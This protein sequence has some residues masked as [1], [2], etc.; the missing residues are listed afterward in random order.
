MYILYKDTS[1]DFLLSPWVSTELCGAGRHRGVFFLFIY[2]QSCV[3]RE[4]FL[5]LFTFSLFIHRTV[6]REKTSCDFLFHYLSTKCVAWEDIVRFSTFSLFIHRTVWCGKTSCDF[7]LF[8]YP[9]TRRTVWRGKTSCDFPFFS[10]FM[11]RIVRSGKTSCD[12][13]L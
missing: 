7:L 6:W 3:A 4:D 11:H 5:W 2:P 12:F 8:I 1:C 9:Q 13:L 10:L